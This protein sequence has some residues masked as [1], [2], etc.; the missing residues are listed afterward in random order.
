MF[1]AF[2]VVRVLIVRGWI[3]LRAQRGRPG[4]EDIATNGM[5]LHPEKSHQLNAKVALAQQQAR[6]QGVFRGVRSSNRAAV[7]VYMYT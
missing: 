4:T 5:C 6:S 1:Q 3:T 7:R 2:P